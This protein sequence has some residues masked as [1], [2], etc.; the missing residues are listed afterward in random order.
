MLGEPL[1]PVYDLYKYRFRR[2]KRKV[3]RK[4]RRFDP[5]R[6]GNLPIFVLAFVLL[7]GFS[8]YLVSVFSAPDPSLQANDPVYSE[9]AVAWKKRGDTDDIIGEAHDAEVIAVDPVASRK[10]R[11]DDVVRRSKEHLKEH[12]SR[13]PSAADMQY[14]VRE[15]F[16]HAWG[17]YEEHA[18]GH[19]EIRPT[20]NA[21]NDSWGGFGATLIDALDTML[22]MG[23]SD[24]FERSVRHLEANLDFDKDYDCSFFETSIRM[25]GGLLGAYEL[26]GERFLLEQATDLATRLLPSFNTPTGL[27]R[28]VVNLRTG[29]AH[30]HQWAGGSILAEVGSIQLE[31][32]YLSK[33]TGDAK[34][35]K[36]A[37]KVMEALSKAKTKQGMSNT[38][39]T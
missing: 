36:A 7:S 19:D 32:K 20:T 5:T 28:S 33:V 13:L 2:F 30:N 16:K 18:M 37:D 21:T 6:P 38:M 9:E 15:A 8:F 27:P 10:K 26:S 29:K 14:A 34:F 25:L 12:H 4:F 23:L 39:T 24:E 11:Q 35:A 17:G 3:V 31:F 22:V 1:P